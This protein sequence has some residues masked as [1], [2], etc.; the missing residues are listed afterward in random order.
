MHEELLIKAGLSLR[1]VKIYE[2]LRLNQELMA[3]EIAK[4]TG[5]IRTNAY[6]V[7]N[8]LIKKGLVSYVIRNNRKYFKG[9]EPE[10][11]IDYLDT[12]EEDLKEIKED[13][14]KILPKLKPAQPSTDRPIIE[15]YEG[16]EGFK[17]IL[18][19]SIRESLRTGKEIIGISVQQQKCRVLGGP[20]HIRWYKERER[21]KI[22]SRYLMSAEE[23]I[24]PVEYTK[25]KRLPPEAKNPNEIFIFGDV[26]TQFFFIGNLFTAIVIK[27][28][29]ITDNWRN[30]FDFL[31][32]MIK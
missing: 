26:T 30:Y 25:F 5:L 15:V 29:E 19:M 32:T 27:N 24:I 31:W 16:R 22:K 11:I 7:L 9:T 20:Y 6:D 8:S 23:K 17:T 12:K 28:K 3:N 18:S 21:L 14:K 4:K 13:I 2:T 1:E 10:K